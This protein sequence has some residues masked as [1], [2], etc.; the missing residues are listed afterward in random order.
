MCIRDRR[1]TLEDGS[2]YHGLKCL[3]YT[4]SPGQSQL[5][6]R[7]RRAERLQ[8][9]R[10]A[11]PRSRK[12]P[13]GGKIEQALFFVAGGKI[14]DVSELFSAQIGREVLRTDFDDPLEGFRKMMAARDVRCYH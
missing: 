12:R 11:S 6:V 10:K 7:K 8:N 3:H 4:S 5:S 2:T 1:K 9:A 13:G 14:H